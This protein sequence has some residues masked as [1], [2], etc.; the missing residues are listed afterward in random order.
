MATLPLARVPDGDLLPDVLPTGRAALRRAAGGVSLLSSGTLEAL[1]RSSAHTVPGTGM[2]FCVRLLVSFSVDTF[3]RRAVVVVCWGCL[4]LSV[5]LARL[6]SSSIGVAQLGTIVPN[7]ART[8]RGDD[9]N[10]FLQPVPFTQDDEPCSS[11]TAE[12]R[13]PD[14]QPRFCY[15]LRFEHRRR[16]STLVAD[17]APVFT[18]SRS[19]SAEGSSHQ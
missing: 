9:R 4:W 5:V 16:R 1:R 8:R 3:C 11:I 7:L 10:D 18:S 15:L 19:A 14:W 17:R 13:E 12:P 2:H 6:C